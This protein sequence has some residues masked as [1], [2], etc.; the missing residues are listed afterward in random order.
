MPRQILFL[1]IG[2]FFGSGLGFF[3]AA[4]NNA[5]LDGHDHGADG[6]ASPAHGGGHD[7]GGGS[8]VPDGAS[9][10]AAAH[11]HDTPLSLPAGPDAPTLDLRIEKDPV[12]GWNLKIETGNFRFAPEAV[13]GAPAANQGHAH[14]YVDGEKLARVYAPWFHLGALPRGRHVISVSLN[15]NDHRPLAVDGTPLEASRTVT[16]E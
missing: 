9:A 4:A 5:T 14:V 13:N 16:V 15:A 7:S 2:L 11:R 3:V 8:S 12:G 6:H 10:M 1:L